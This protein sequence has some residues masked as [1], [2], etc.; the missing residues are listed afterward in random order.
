M[1]SISD[2]PV[3]LGKILDSLG[4]PAKDYVAQ[5][6]RIDGLTHIQKALASL[7]H[8]ISL[9]Q[10]EELWREFSYNKY[11]SWLELP[12]SLKEAELA[13]LE[14]CDDIENGENHSGL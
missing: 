6:D 4:L 14:F 8:N 9:S 12:S 3:A 13:I 5:E 7:G 11:A 2:F 10:S 1:K